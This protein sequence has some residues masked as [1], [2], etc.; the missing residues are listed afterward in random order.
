MNSSF[1]SYGKSL[2]ACEQS[3]QHSFGKALGKIL[4]VSAAGNESLENPTACPQTMATHTSIVVA[5][6]ENSNSEN[7]VLSD[8][9]NRGETYAD[10]AA[11]GYSMNG[12]LEGTSFAAPRVSG[13]AAK[14]AYTYD[15]LLPQDIRLAILT[16]AHIPAKK[17][18]VR[19]GGVLR[20]ER[21]MAMASCLHIDAEVGRQQGK[22]API[23]KRQARRCLS[24]VDG[25]GGGK[26]DAQID[27]LSSRPLIFE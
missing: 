26:A 5:A 23:T 6:A 2:Q 4:S 1:T 17:L 3:A 22:T 16:T 8:Y 19:T 25:F 11:H 18:P 13:V 20:G 14:I 10:I 24:T 27:F 15:H 7:P 9:S 21:A 12:E